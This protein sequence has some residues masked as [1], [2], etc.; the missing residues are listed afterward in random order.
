MEA[1][2]TETDE[3]DEAD[4]TDELDEA[5]GVVRIPDMFGETAGSGKGEKGWGGLAAAFPEPPPASPPGAVHG[6]L[7]QWRA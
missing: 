5:A 4:E 2:W 7:V 6:R 1:E 3:A